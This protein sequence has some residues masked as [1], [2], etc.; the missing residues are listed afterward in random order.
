MS[1]KGHILLYITFMLCYSM[2][3]NIRCYLGYEGCHGFITAVSV[4]CTVGL[5]INR[6]VN[7]FFLRYLEGANLLVI[8]T[9]NYGHY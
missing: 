2:W 7:V 4:S 3:F 6:L 1:V 8:I 5:F 9:V